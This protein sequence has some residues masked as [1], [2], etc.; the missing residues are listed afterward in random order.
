MTFPCAIC[1]SKSATIGFFVKPG[2]AHEGEFQ[3]NL[4]ECESAGVWC[5]GCSQVLDLLPSMELW[6]KK[7]AGKLPQEWKQHQIDIHRKRAAPAFSDYVMHDGDWNET[8][9]TLRKQFTYT[10]DDELRL[11]LEA[12]GELP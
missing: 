12:M 8:M 10:K 9:N 4:D 2:I 1:G 11:A 7:R 5:D 3:F 6:I